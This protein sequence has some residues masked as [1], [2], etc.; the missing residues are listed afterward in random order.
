MKEEKAGFA[1]TDNQRYQVQRLKEE[2]KD[3][4]RQSEVMDAQKMLFMDGRLKASKELGTGRQELIEEMRKSLMQLEHEDSSLSLF[5]KERQSSMKRESKKRLIDDEVLKSYDIIQQ[6][7]DAFENEAA[8]KSSMDKKDLSRK[9][10]NF[11]KSAAQK[12]ILTQNSIEQYLKEKRVKDIK[13]QHLERYK[14][15]DLLQL[16]QKS[17]TKHNLKFYENH[18]LKRLTRLFSK[19]SWLK[20]AEIDP[21]N[22]DFHSI[23]NLDENNYFG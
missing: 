8:A 22:I 14:I 11:D 19:V 12:A 10:S 3:H 13:P 23:Q 17:E 6:Q 7:Q 5:N 15:N 2:K 21:A 9:R 1:G 16:A 20:L 18:P 4:A